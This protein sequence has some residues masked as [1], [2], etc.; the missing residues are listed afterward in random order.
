MVTAR[1]RWA[2]EWGLHKKSQWKER[3]NSENIKSSTTGSAFDWGER[4]SGAHQIWCPTPKSENED[5]IP[6][7]LS[8]PIFEYSIIRD[9]HVA[10]PDKNPIWIKRQNI[11]SYPLTILI[12]A[13]FLS[14]S[15][16]RQVM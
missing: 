2:G 1:C 9:T 14:N 15:A 12:A 3:S 6:S 11:L 16:L 5:S 7:V 10:L 13:S 4:G 8:F